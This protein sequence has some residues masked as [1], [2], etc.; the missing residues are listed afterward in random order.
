MADKK[1]KYAL[2]VGGRGWLIPIEKAG[3]YSLHVRLRGAWGR[4][5]AGPAKLLLDLPPTK[6]QVN[7]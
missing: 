7:K 3:S 2:I 5:G 6:L 4:G 1:D